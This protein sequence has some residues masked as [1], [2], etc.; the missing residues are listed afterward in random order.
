[1]ETCLVGLLP[2][3]ASAVDVARGLEAYTS[4]YIF[5][6][7]VIVQNFTARK[8]GERGRISGDSTVL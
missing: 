4:L 3:A 5:A 6:M 1:M 7:A 8:L 2:S